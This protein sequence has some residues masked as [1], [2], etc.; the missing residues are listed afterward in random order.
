M[1]DRVTSSVLCS[2][3]SSAFS[4]ACSG[5]Q[6]RVEITKGGFGLRPSRATHWASS[7]PSLSLSFLTCTLRIRVATS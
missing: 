6:N 5:R 7:I 1:S 2:G 3:A 4:F